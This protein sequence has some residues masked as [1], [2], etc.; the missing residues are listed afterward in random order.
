M[1]RIV[2]PPT[3]VI[4]KATGTSVASAMRLRTAFAA[5]QPEGTKASATDVEARIASD[6]GMKP[7]Q[8]RTAASNAKAMGENRAVRRIYLSIRILPA[9]L[10]SQ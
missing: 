1:W 5:H 6:R 2:A 10:T 9:S 7:R 4:A 8:A 3:I